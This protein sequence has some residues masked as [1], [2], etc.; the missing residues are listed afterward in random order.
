MADRRP[1]RLTERDHDLL[2]FVAVHRLVLAEHVKALLGV[3]P[4][5]AYNRLRSLAAAGML[6]TEQPYH[7]RPGH[8]QITRRGLDAIASELPRPGV[9]VRSY[10]HDIGLAWLWL[11]ARSGTFGQLREVVSERQMRSH[12]GRL[13]DHGERYG[14]RLGGV[15]P[16]GLERRHYP[17]LIL[18]TAGGHRVAIELELSGKARTRRETILAG[19]GA[20]RRIDAVLYFVEHQAVSR[21]IRT[22]AARLGISP[23][24]H[25]QRFEHGTAM[26]ATGRQTGIERG[27][28][29]SLAAEAG[30]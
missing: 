10:Q 13:G 6:S 5:A 25:V 1:V 24:I 21:A 22:S 29:R 16:R 2:A 17:D 4:A 9:D 3:S 20:D 15:G 28:T 8:Y 26:R 14:V 7:N 19:Y 30:R 23:L 12:D 11:A 18:D 27:P